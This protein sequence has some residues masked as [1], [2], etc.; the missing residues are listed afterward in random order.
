VARD[1]IR[2]LGSDQAP[3]E[4]IAAALLHDV[5]KVE[6]SFGTFA[7]VG[8]TFAALAFGRSRLLRWAGDPSES[9]RPSRRA[10]VGLY[11]TH[12]RLGAKLL[13]RAGSQALT[14]S[15]AAEHHLA[16]ELWT[17]DATIG[18]ALKAADGD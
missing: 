15:W 14:V 4:V 1:T 6:S 8:V 18:A 3:R 11:L 9:G 16:P 17:V 10:R 13:E 7:R 2:L 5:G 12:D